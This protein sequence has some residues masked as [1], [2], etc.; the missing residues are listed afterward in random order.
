MGKNPEECLVNNG[1]ITT[2]LLSEAPDN[3]DIKGTRAS[4]KGM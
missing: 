4:S 1:M 3:A 2:T